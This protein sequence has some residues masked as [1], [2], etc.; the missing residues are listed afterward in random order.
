M[1]FEE[2][3]DDLAVT[4]TLLNCEAS[5]V[6]V[7]DVRMTGRVEVEFWFAVSGDSRA[8]PTEVLDSECGKG[9][10]VEWVDA[11]SV[12]ARLSNNH[13]LVVEKVLNDLRKSGHDI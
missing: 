6:V 5:S 7:R 11:G 2:G 12:K 13:R 9:W 1:E 8:G 3:E 4:E 10:R